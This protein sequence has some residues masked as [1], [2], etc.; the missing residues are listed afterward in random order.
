MPNMDLQNVIM[1]NQYT[2]TITVSIN[3]QNHKF[4]EILVD[5]KQIIDKI[6]SY[7]SMHLQ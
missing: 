7:I 3:F 4:I 6:L 2:L 1:Y 5:N